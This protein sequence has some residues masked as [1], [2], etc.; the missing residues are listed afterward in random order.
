[1]TQ[2]TLPRVMALHCSASSPRQWIPYRQRLAPGIEL[3]TPSI[4]QRPPGRHDGL[5]DAAA[6]LWAGLGDGPVHLVGHSFGAALALTMALQRPRSVV[7]ATL[8]EPI[9]FAVLQGSG[10]ERAWSEIHEVGTRIGSLVAAGR[11]AQAG[12][13]FCD[14]WGDAGAW[15]RMGATRRT[16]VATRM[17]DVAW[18]FEALFGQALRPQELAAPDLPIMVLC[19]QRSPE[20]AR[21]CSEIVADSCADASLVRID[22]AGHMAPVDRPN[23]VLQLLPFAAAVAAERPPVEPSAVSHPG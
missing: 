18:N 20:P 6:Q 22:G 12:E 9:V 14:Y 17:D 5:Q 19:G 21:R 8:Y 23:L 3:L 11:L 1:M 2:T 13:Q 16:A 4:G 7:S 10:T 15:A